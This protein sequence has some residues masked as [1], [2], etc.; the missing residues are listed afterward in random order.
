MLFCIVGTGRSGTTLLQRMLGSHPDLFVFPETHWLPNIYERFGNTAASP[1]QIAD[2]VRR[3]HHV[4]GQPT[5]D[6][7][8]ARL[9]ATFDGDVT[10]REFADALGNMHA[11]D[12][13]KPHWADKTP[14]YGYFIGTLQ[15]LWPDC[16]FIHLIRDGVAVACS[17]A[18]HPG[19]QVLA[20]SEQLFWCPMSL[21]YTP[22]TLSRGEEDPRQFVRLW[23]HRLL[24]TRDEYKKLEKG[25]VREFRF[26]ELVT[27][28]ASILSSICAFTGLEHNEQ[29]MMDAAA[30]VN[31][32]KASKSRPTE[33]L[34]YFDEEGMQLLAD[35]GYRDASA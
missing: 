10:V 31:P 3:T 29:W 26:E 19:Y 5:T 17:M 4:N 21:D 6:F 18:R 30:L 22:D 25:S 34:E 13:G 1:Y 15:R 24:R 35:L 23:Q 8:Q 2:I 7:D 16:K 9:L 14:D 11:A 27:D 20:R 33:W 12:A 32:A 28:P